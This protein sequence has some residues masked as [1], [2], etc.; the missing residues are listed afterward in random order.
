[1]APTGSL[2][3]AIT[4]PPARCGSQL[5]APDVLKELTLTARKRR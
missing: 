5:E 4:E 2:L 3:T 1:M